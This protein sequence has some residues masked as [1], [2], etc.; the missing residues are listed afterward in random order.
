MQKAQ[1]KDLKIEISK[2]LNFTNSNLK[3]LQIKDILIKNIFG[4]IENIKI[5]DGDI[6]FN[7]DKGI[8]INSNFDSEIKLNNKF[9]NLLDRY[10]FIKNIQNFDATLN[11]NVFIE[12][13]HTYK[14]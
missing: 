5:S 11:N 12:L 10:G 9:S 14:F 6:K 2:D 8:K 1:V 4:E 7:F 3:F 13:D